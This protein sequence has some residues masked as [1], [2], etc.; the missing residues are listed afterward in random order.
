M[1]FFDE[2]FTKEYSLT[3]DNSAYLFQFHIIFDYEGLSKIYDK[4]IILI[5]KFMT[6]ISF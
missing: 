6:N 1:L 4:H 2:P 3:L 5:V